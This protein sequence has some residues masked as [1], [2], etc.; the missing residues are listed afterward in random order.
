MADNDGLR[1]NGMCLTPT[2]S[3]VQASHLWL[4]PTS[5]LWGQ[6][7]LA[8]PHHPTFLI[9]RISTTSSSSF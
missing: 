2:L 7:G 8:L 6:A 5:H 9:D 3:S 4:G 1:M